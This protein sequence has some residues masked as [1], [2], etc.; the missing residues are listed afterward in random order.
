MDKESKNQFIKFVA[1][2]NSV[3]TELL[4]ARK[5]NELATNVNKRE[6]LQND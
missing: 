6:K 2:F 5:R 3:N 1:V 4:I